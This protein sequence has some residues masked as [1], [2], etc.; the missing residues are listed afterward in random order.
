VFDDIGELYI[1]VESF[2]AEEYLDAHP[3]SSDIITDM[4]V[5]R[6]WMRSL[7]DFVPVMRQ[8]LIRFDLEAMTTQMLTAGR[9]ATR[10]FMRL[11]WEFMYEKCMELVVRITCAFQHHLTLMCTVMDDYVA[12]MLLQAIKINEIKFSSVLEGTS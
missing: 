7:E 9:S 3:K 11:I 12:S 4:K 6:T 10:A 1:F 5:M 2:K 8:E